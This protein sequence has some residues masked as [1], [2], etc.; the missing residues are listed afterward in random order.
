[1]KEMAQ[2]QPR[3]MKIRKASS[4]EIK[5]EIDTLI[6]DIETMLKSKNKTMA[7]MRKD[8]DDAAPILDAVCYTGDEL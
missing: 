2:L 4:D 5:I 7:V 3:L 1:M 6:R 8:L